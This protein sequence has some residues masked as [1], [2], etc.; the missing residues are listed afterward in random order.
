MGVN[1]SRVAPRA[2]PLVTLRGDRRRP[3]PVAPAELAAVLPVGACLRRCRCQGRDEP[4]AWHSRRATDRRSPAARAVTRTS[5][6]SRRRKTLKAGHGPPLPISLD[7]SATPK[8][9]RPS[10]SPRSR[11]C[12]RKN[13][14]R[15]PKAPGSRPRNRPRSSQAH[16]GSGGLSTLR[17]QPA[18]PGRKIRPLPP[19]TPPRPGKSRPDGER[20]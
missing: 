17:H 15:R 4:V 19:S 11:A 2:V 10:A 1:N 18:A 5:S 8:R 3:R 14:A 7:R 16:V 13:R 9:H 12:L 20:P 6:R